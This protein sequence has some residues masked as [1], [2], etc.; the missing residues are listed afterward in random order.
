[1]NA[2][3]SD[4]RVILNAL[5]KVTR[6]LRD[7]GV[8]V[9]LKPGVKSVATS[10]EVVEY[11][12][13]PMIEGYVDA[14]LE[15]GT[16]LSWRLDVRWTEVSFEIDATLER[17]SGAGSETLRQLPESVIRDARELPDALIEVTRS[18]LS[19]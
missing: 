11:D 14:E 5:A 12:N 1:M 10:L 4:T 7:H 17:I 16:A 13:G 2:I 19:Q 8:S 3:E 9:R 6:L 15:D 18:L